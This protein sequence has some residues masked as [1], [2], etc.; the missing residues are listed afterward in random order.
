MARDW[1]LIIDDELAGTFLGQSTANKC[2]TGIRAA[3]KERGETPPEIEVKH[4]KGT[5]WQTR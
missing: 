4:R 3:F 5:K 2:A 1:L